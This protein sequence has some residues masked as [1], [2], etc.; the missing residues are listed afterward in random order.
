MEAQKWHNITIKQ[1]QF[2]QS[3]GGVVLANGH[4]LQDYLWVDNVTDP[5]V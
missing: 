3:N 5:I 1:G 2:K 4:G